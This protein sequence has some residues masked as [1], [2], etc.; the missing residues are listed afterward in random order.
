MGRCPEQLR[1]PGADFTNSFYLLSSFPAGPESPDLD[2]FL[3]ALTAQ[4]ASLEELRLAFRPQMDPRQLSMMLML[5]QSNPQ[6]LAL[7]GT[8]ASLARELERVERQSRLEQLSPAE[9]HSKN[10]SHWA[11]WL[12]EYRARLEKDQEAAGD[13]VAWQAERARV[14]HANN[15]KYV[16][17]NY[18]AQGAIQAAESGDFSEVRR[19]LKLLETPYR[20]EGEAAEAC[21]VAEPEEASGEAGGAASRRHSYSCK[22]PLWAAELCVT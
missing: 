9:L 20:G 5:A 3:A 10:R 22:P 14:M 17:R 7:I 16:L 8:R 19:V 15:P 2:E 1:V 4:C 13:T 6:L 11:E 18:I 21:E 12:L